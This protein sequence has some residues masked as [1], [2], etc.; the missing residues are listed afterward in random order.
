MKPYDLTTYQNWNDLSID[1]TAELN[2][3]VK[4]PIEVK[5]TKY[6]DGKITNL[7]IAISNSS[8]FIMADIDFAGNIIPLAINR[9]IARNLL[10]LPEA[11]T[12]IITDF[13]KAGEELQLEVKVVDAQR[14]REAYELKKQ[15]EE[16]AKQ[17]AKLQAAKEKAIQEFKS[18][19]NQPKRF[20]ATG[21]FYY[22]LGWLAKNAGTISAALP[23]YLLSSFESQFGTDANPTV[24]DSTKRTVGGFPTQWALSMKVS[25]PKKAQDSIPAVFFD[26]LNPNRTAITKT[27]LV[28]DLIDNYGFQFGKTQDVDKIRDRILVDYI[29]AFENGYAA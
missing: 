1:L 24:V 25:L 9:A 16:L 15:A 19:A 29:E 12:T 23:D 10:T 7:Q 4:T 26:C 3:L 13:A 6:G 22:A 2:E 18:L 27:N 8:F 11:E 14:A 20:S 17:E 28:W 21:E 5:H